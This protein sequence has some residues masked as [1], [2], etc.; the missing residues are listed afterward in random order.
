MV[1]IR[2]L[3]NQVAAVVRRAGAGERVIVTVDGKPVAQLG[4]IEPVGTPTL[5]DLVAA[6]LV[7]PPSSSSSEALEA[8]IEV[9]VDAGAARVVA[10]VRGE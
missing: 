4:P 10:E 2:E 5:Q 9:A 7:H 8:P 3:R 1:G 6:G